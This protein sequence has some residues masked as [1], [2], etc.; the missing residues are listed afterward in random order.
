M[1]VLF[2][3]PDYSYSKACSRVRELAQAGVAPLNSLYNRIF[4]PLAALIV[5]GT[6]LAWWVASY[7]LTEALESRVREQLLHAA[8]IIAGQAFPLT[9]EVLKRLAD[10]QQSELIVLDAANR[11]ALSTLKAPELNSQIIAHLATR[12]S[13]DAV[14]ELYRGDEEL[15]VV[16]RALDPSRNPGFAQIALLGSLAVAQHAARQAALWLGLIAICGVAVLAWWAHRSV[17]ALTQP[18]H[19]LA[20][21]ATQIAGGDRSI[22]AEINGTQETRALALALND[23]TVNIQQFEQR[24]AEQNRLAALGELAA[25]VA[26]EIRN[27]LTAIQLQA[28]ML[29]E[30]SQ[31]T[32]VQSNARRLVSEIKRLDLIVA[33]TLAL[34]RE[35]TISRSPTNLTPVIEEVLTLM[36]PSLAHRRIDLSWELIDVEPISL[37]G[38]RFKQVI[39]NLLTNAADE[40]GS[41]GRIAVHTTATD[42][43]VI[44]TVEDTGSGVAD[45]IVEGLTNGTVQSTKEGGL[46]V[47]LNLSRELV[48]LHDGMMRIERSAD[49]GGAAFHIHLPRES[50][51]G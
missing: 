8:D 12:P 33:S 26:H 2:T 38:D 27:P 4:L 13:P 23:M 3:H 47:G 36:Q 45:Q 20:Q 19:A 7:L 14:G 50:S 44:V 31:H 29:L 1:M 43:D 9:P 39:F 21:M 40:I 46:G 35:V 24:L 17:R 11:V 6:A 30:H 28:E 51:S 32:V 34:G 15:L 5:A 22:R 48:E 16:V 49:L 10:I 41:D 25:R 37:D 42:Q 18:V